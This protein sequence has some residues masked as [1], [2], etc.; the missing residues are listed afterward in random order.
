MYVWTEA[1]AGEGFFNLGFWNL[2]ASIGSFVLAVGVFMFIV[3]VVHTTRKA[4]RAPLDPWDARTL[5]WMTSSPP[6]EWNFDS[7]PEVHAL[8][9][10]FH[11]KYEDVG[12]DGHH[13]LRRVATAEEVLAGEEARA[14]HHIH[15]PSASYWPLVLAS[16]LPI[17]ALGVIYAPLVGFVGAA[18]A[19]LAM[20]G[21]ALEPSVAPETDFDPEPEEPGT[22]LAT[23]GGDA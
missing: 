2:V 9:E 10:Y 20:F 6:K 12:S 23:V 18:I 13:D 15:L 8:D 5:E 19:L 3:N 1:R 17:I 4:P 16:S 7:L 21:W 22:E 11:R 14:D